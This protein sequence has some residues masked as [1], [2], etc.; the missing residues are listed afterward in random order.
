MNARVVTNTQTPEPTIHPNK[1]VIIYILLF[2][3]IGL[4][5]VIYI[6]EH[7]IHLSLKGVGIPDNQIKYPTDKLD[8][9]HP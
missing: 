4:D 3:F 8:M 5:F 1:K 7:P 6:I 9:G 2:R